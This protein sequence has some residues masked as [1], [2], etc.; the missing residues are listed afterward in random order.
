MKSNTKLGLAFVG[1]LAGAILFLYSST[2]IAPNIVRIPLLF[3]GIVFL[4]LSFCWFLW[5]VHYYQESQGTLVDEMTKFDTAID[6]CLLCFVLWLMPL[7]EL[8]AA[9]VEGWV[10]FVL[11]PCVIARLIIALVQKKRQQK[12]KTTSQER[13]YFLWDDAGVWQIQVSTWNGL[14]SWSVSLSV[15]S[16]S[17][18][19]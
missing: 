16:C 6:M 19:S 17:S 9:P 3:L 13:S 18:V 14:V 2:E 4:S 15:L 5:E 7:F 12:E 8:I 10:I 1:C 11:A